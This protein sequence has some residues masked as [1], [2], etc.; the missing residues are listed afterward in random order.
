[1]MTIVS[2]VGARPE[3]VQAAPVS[4]ALRGRHRE[5]LVHTGQHYDYA[6]SKAFFEDLDIP[7]PSWHLDAGSGTHAQQ[8]ARMLGAF[9]D[10]LARERPDVVVVRG[11]T[12]STVAGGLAA[13]K[14]G[15]P[16]VHIEAGER[17]FDRRMPEEIN[18]VLVDHL[19]SAHLCASRRG[20][21]HL[22]SEGI[23]TTVTFVGDVM[24][25]ALLRARDVAAHRSDVLARLGL[26]P[27]GYALV[28]IHRAGNTDDPARLRALVEAVNAA[29]EP[30]V[31]PVHPRTQAAL[32][33]D[34]LVFAPHVVAIAPV[35][36]LDMLMLE[37]HAR[38]IATDSGGVQ[39]E[40]YYLSV[41]CLTLRDE[42]EW[43]ETVDVGW[44]RLV[45]ADVVAIRDAW[46]N[47]APA[48]D[49]PPIYGDG[50]AGVRIAEALE[51]AFGVLAGG[52]H[53][54]GGR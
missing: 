44:N 41:P 17:S 48:A 26:R 51:A 19:A 20:V 11:D 28:T 29:P 36:Y 52:G 27:K 25:D 12:N 33:R 49:H 23:R 8:T 43:M 39:R 31:F 1:M 22:A 53:T 7:E 3:F 2:V 10:V 30:V 4:R 40:A 24:C 16:V 54:G 9:D 5:V 46:A 47:F 35:R 37:A 38:I 15:I 34:G 32:E 50:R 13:V 6:M 21:A 18:R 45:G 14:R 42:T